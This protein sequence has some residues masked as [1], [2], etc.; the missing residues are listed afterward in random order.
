MNGAGD[1]ACKQANGHD[2]PVFTSCSFA[3]NTHTHTTKY[4]C[5]KKT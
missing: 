3:K 4:T 2:V 1:E 5:Q